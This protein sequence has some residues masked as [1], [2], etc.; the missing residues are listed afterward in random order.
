ML[1]AD[2][3]MSTALRKEPPDGDNSRL[4]ALRLQMEKLR[5]DNIR[6]TNAMLKRMALE[7]LKKP[8]KRL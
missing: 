8:R 1:L 5:L 4:E 2:T 3:I 6:E 7:Y